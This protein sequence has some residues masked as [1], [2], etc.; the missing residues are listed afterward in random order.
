[1]DTKVSPNTNQESPQI[2]EERK[3]YIEK[4]KKKFYEETICKG[5]LIP[6]DKKEKFEEF[7]R[8][9]LFENQ[10]PRDALGMTDEMMEFIYGQGYKMYQSGQIKEAAEVFKMLALLNINEAKYSIALGVCYVQQKN[11]DYA[12]RVFATAMFIDQYD[13]YPAMQMA[14]CYLKLG[15]R[16][17]ALNMFTIAFERAVQNPLYETIAERLVL[18]I[19][20][21]DKT[22]KDEIVLKLKNERKAKK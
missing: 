11:W 19:E 12:I 17:S 7:F 14:E 3:A 16:Y 9:I 4:E 18:T 1:M 20:T 5:D 21:L 13:P 22:L 2:S 15:D 8:K 6:E 10:L